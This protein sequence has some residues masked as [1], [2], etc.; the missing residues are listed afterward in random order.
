MVC[1]GAWA[2]YQFLTKPKARTQDA[3]TV[4]IRTAKV[5]SGSI[6]RVLRLTGATAAKNF[7]MVAAPMMRGPD[8]GRALVLI[9]VAKS[10]GMVKKGEVVAQI[11]AQSMKDHV[12]D[13]DTQVLQAD[14]DIRKRKA[15]QEL[16]WEGLQQNI[17]VTKAALEKSKLDTSAA[18]VRTA[19]DAEL[20]KL[21]VE[22]QEATLKQQMADLASQKIAF[23][24]EIRIL[25]ITKA[26]HASHRDRHAHD[27]EKFTIQS[28]IN[29]LAVM[30]SIWRGS[31]MGQV[32][33]GDQISPGQPFMQIVDTSGML[34]Q[35]RASQVESDEMRLGQPAVVSFD[36][37]PDLK[38][39]AQ[40]SS[41]GAIATGG[42]SVNYFLRTVPVYLSISEHDSRVIPDLSTA[43][44]VVVDQ[45]EK[46]LLIPRE[47]LESKDG[48]WFVRVKSGDQF[49]A[50]E[51]K[52]GTGDNLNVAVQ[53]GLR[54]GEEV[55]IDKPAAG[56]LLASS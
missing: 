44:N 31:E 47:A 22:E 56:P 4:G 23:A 33:Q 35:S 49:V 9:Y 3:Q 12:D 16:A 7:S 45:S 26:R 38:L 30:Q 37:F 2:G 36:A 20:L 54:E 39:K 51:V 24:A 41:I 29:G 43:A 5:T 25:E 48:K 32:Q 14:A 50:R 1:A 53:D 8:A 15:E 46:T 18:E 42:R 21:S 34:V 17:R 11:D 19:I 52:L 13:I 27:I 10:G 28:P 6:K 55:A 40:V